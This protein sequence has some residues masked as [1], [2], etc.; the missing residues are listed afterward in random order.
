MKKRIVFSSLREQ[1]EITQAEFRKLSPIERLRQLR[2]DIERLYFKELQS[3][4][5]G[6]IRII[7]DE[8]IP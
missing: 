8:Y 4:R 6:K 5:N 7:V 2:K 1:S 3:K